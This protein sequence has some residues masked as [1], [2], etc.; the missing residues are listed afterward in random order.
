MEMLDQSGC[1]HCCNPLPQEFKCR[2]PREHSQRARFTQANSAAEPSPAFLEVARSVRV[3]CSYNERALVRKRLNACPWPAAQ[4][5]GNEAELNLVHTCLAPSLAPSGGRS[6]GPQTPPR[7]QLHKC[8]VHNLYE[9]IDYACSSQLRSLDLL[10]YAPRQFYVCV[11]FMSKREG[12]RER[13]VVCVLSMFVLHD[14]LRGEEEIKRVTHIKYRER[15][16]DRER[17]RLL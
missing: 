14:G 17:R 2:W 10:M 15:E 16:D 3:P 8:T 4:G 1:N 11:C 12:Q 5:R 7:A 6:L 13:A 9:P